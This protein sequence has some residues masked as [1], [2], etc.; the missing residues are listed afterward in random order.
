MVFSITF[1]F[2]F[3][4]RFSS[5]FIEDFFLNSNIKADFNKIIIEFFFSISIYKI[6]VYY[7]IGFVLII[8]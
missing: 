4:K 7:K 3:S 6:K 2:V 5:F 1:P 8:Q